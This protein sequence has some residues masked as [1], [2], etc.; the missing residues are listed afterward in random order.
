MG[1]YISVPRK[2]EGLT[3]GFINTPSSP[4]IPNKALRINGLVS[5]RGGIRGEVWVP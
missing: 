3:K 1:I 2:K 5:L 4:N